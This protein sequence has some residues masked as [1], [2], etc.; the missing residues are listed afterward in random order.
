MMDA[1]KFTKTLAA[2][3]H[4]PHTLIA[5]AIEMAEVLTPALR[6]NIVAAYTEAEN[7]LKD[8]DVRM[9]RAVSGM[10][11]LVKDEERHIKSTTRKQKES[12][13]S[14]PELLNASQALDRTLT[15]SLL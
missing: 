12:A 7:R 14:T 2:F 6:Q 15:S 13:V 1:K 4:I 9:E 11:V 5:R 10:E 8:S 3:Q